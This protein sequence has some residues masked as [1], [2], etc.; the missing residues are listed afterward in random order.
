MK[1]G[2]FLFTQICM[3]FYCYI[4]FSEMRNSF[5]VGSTGDDLNE[6]LRKHN[7]NHKGFTGSVSDWKIVYMGTFDSVSEA[8]KRELQIKK[9]KSR[10]AIE[11]LIKSSPP[12]LSAGSEHPD[13][14]L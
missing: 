6:R 13:A 7:S 10:S 12:N 14:A 4:L 5:Y 9:W 8:R 2:A 1:I 3:P 11:R